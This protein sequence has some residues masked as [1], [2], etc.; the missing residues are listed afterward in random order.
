MH[1][2]QKSIVLLLLSLLTT[3]TSMLLFTSKAYA[4]K[5][6]YPGI[7]GIWNS[8]VSKAGKPWYKGHIA[9]VDWADIE[10]SNGNFSWAPLDNL[11]NNIANQGLY[12]MTMVYTGKGAPHWLYSSGVPVATAGWSGTGD[13]FPYYLNST[14]QTY[15]KRMVA[16][17]AQHLQNAY[18]ST[19]RAKIVGIQAPVGTSGDPEPYRGT[20]QSQYQI[21]STDWIAFSKEMFTYYNSQYTNSNPKIHLLYNLLGYNNEHW[22]ADNLPGSWLKTNRIG[23]RYENAEDGDPNNYQQFTADIIREFY[24]GRALRARSEMDL[25][26]AKKSGWFLEAPL[27][28]MYWTQLWGLTQGQDM[29]NQLQ[30]DL[31]NS[32]YYPAFDFYS[33]YAGYKSPQD[34][35]GVWIAL[36]DGLDETDTTRFQASTYG[37]IDTST[38]MIKIANAMAKYGAKQSDTSVTTTTSFTGLNDVGYKI[39][40]GNYQMWMSQI[41]PQGTSQGLWRVGPQTQMYGRFARRFDHATGKDAM[42][43]TID[44][45]FFFNQGLNGHYP[46]TIRLVYLD[47]GTG[48]FKLQYDSTSGPKDI[49]VTKTNTGQW[50][51]KIVT[52]NDGNFF[53]HLQNNADIALINTDTE[54]D[55]FHM[56]EI[57][58]STGDRKGVWGDGGIVPTNVLTSV[59]TSTPISSPTIGQQNTTK[60]ALTVFLHGIG[61]GGD[62]VNMTSTGNFSPLHPQRNITIELFDSNNQLVTTRSGTVTFSSTNGNFIGTIDIGNVGTGVYTGR[63][64]AATYLRKS[65][66]GIISLSTGQTKTI[67]PI[68]LITGDSNNDNQ[69][70]ILDYNLLLDCFSDLSAARNCSDSNKKVA[71]D[72]TDDGNV[73]QF[74]Y[75]LFLRELSVQTGQ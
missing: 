18:P 2:T 36:H 12:V 23:D 53:N 29:H 57:T 24:N 40:T 72:L 22:I 51:E 17:V 46:V 63:I 8:P 34:S 70:S 44:D 28:N 54:D 4:D 30:V 9:V 31:N 25:T 43:F 21:S 1:R 64:K 13:A 20:I 32:A 42:Y 38:R 62:N 11:V 27:W 33:K 65:L 26:D 60:L 7:W 35:I 66:S 48:S 41:N 58:R 45:R 75:N 3:I 56:I 71:T 61:K 52:L 19:I 55:T 5:P 6:D 68:S 73:N 15:F 69:L 14:Y 74:D 49:L 10:P 50:K 59:P 16:A 37:S 39:Y 67:T 47:Q